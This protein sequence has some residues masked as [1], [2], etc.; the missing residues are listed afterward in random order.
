MT[1]RIDDQRTLGEDGRPLPETSAP[2]AAKVLAERLI[3]Y[4]PEELAPYHRNPRRGD[5]EAIAAAPHRLQD[6][7]GA[8]GL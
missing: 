1:T 2:Y 6:T 8:A 4:G 7:A 5:V 3:E